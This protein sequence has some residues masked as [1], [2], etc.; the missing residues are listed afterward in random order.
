MDYCII[1]YDTVELFKS[2]DAAVLHCEPWQVPEAVIVLADGTVCLVKSDDSI[3]CWL[4]QTPV[5]NPLLFRILLERL[6]RD[7]ERLPVDYDAMRDEELLF[8]AK[9]LAE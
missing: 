8:I 4:A 3:K 6:L 2:R 1:V 7:T 5:K 9:E